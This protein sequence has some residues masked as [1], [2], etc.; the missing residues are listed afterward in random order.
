MTSYK[1]DYELYVEKQLERK[2]LTIEKFTDEIIISKKCLGFQIW[3]NNYT[4]EIVN[5]LEIEKTDV[6]NPDIKQFALAM[7]IFILNFKRLNSAFELTYTDSAESNYNL[8]RIVFESILF[9]FYLYNHP[10]ETDEINVFFNERFLDIDTPSKKRKE[11]TAKELEVIDR[12][13]KYSPKKIRDSLY[14]NEQKVSIE[15]IYTVLSTQSHAAIETINGSHYS[16]SERRIKDMFWYVKLLSFYNIVT[17]LENLPITRNI[18]HDVK[19]NDV[20]KSLDEIKNMAS[21]G[22]TLGDFFPNHPNKKKSRLY[23]L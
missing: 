6:Q 13:S 4:T 10:E 12:Q 3:L 15:K 21:E 7:Q 23:N 1:K 17:F 11:C 16:Y 2:S 19:N 5:S 22:R 8:F 9:S 20:L 14:V 18:A